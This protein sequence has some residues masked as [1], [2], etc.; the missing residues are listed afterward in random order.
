MDWYYYIDKQ[1]TGPISEEDFHELVNSGVVRQDTLVWH[2]GMEGW[3]AYGTLVN[4]S[5]SREAMLP[6]GQVKCSECQKV[7]SEDEVI[8]HGESVICEDCKPMF[9]QKL[10]EGS[11]TDGAMHYAGFWIRAGAKIIDMIIISIIQWIFFI[12]A[13]FL[14]STTDNPSMAIVSGI[15]IQIFSLSLNIGYLT[16]FHGK[17]SATPGKMAC[18]LKVVVADG[19]KITYLRAFGRVFAE[20]LSGMILAIGYMMAGWDKEKRTLHDRICDTRV[21]RK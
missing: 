11:W 20:W 9:L 7:L 16:F 6:E 21:V 4:S 10:K 12:P 15:A 3:K 14:L 19:S 5:E 17:Y 2:A 8:R 1:Q 18:G 13:G